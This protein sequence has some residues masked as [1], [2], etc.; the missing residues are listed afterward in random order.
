MSQPPGTHIRYDLSTAR[1]APPRGFGAEVYRR[2]ARLFL[3]LSGWKTAGDFPATPKAVVLAAPHTSNWDG[4]WM[5]A[6]AGKYRI[7]LHWMGKAS[8][9]RGPFGWLAKLSGLIPIDRSGGKDLVRAT[10][11]ALEQA[12][13]LLIAIAP[14]GTR[15]SVGEWKSG[16]YH[17][18]RLASVPIVFAVMDYGSRTIRIS[19][20]LWPSGDYEA[21]LA[22][23][24][25]HY[26]DA[27]G[28]H[29]G[30]FSLGGGK[31]T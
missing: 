14:E 17:I 12:D 20:E 2:A 25:T 24:R 4:V 18:A 16:F 23:I 7:R 1:I 6:A 27:R 28:R 30:R 13:R 10:A 9:A 5:I 19:G 11:D 21:D 29:A 31:Q 15:G 3:A 8:L 26:A 22:L